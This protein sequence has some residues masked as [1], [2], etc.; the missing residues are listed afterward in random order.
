M[1]KL[2]ALMLAILLLFALCCAPAR[3]AVQPAAGETV[4]QAVSMHISSVES[5]V[6]VGTLAIAPSSH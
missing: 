4:T 5:G 2:I 1:K 3:I 6:D